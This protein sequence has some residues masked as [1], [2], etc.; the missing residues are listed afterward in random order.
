VRRLFQTHNLGFY[1]NINAV[2]KQYTAR[3]AAAAKSPLK[4]QNKL[5]RPSREG[6]KFR[7]ENKV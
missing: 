5:A 6:M 1:K 2:C 3:T 4:A 7:V